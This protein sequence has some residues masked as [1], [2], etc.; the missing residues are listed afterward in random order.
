[1]FTAADRLS[2]AASTL[3]GYARSAS[4]LSNHEVPAGWIDG[5]VETATKCEK[6]IDAYLTERKP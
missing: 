1:M 5:L 4:W 2:L 3:V 6:A